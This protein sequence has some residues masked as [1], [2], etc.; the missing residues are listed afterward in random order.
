MAAY[1]SLLFQ[2]DT[3]CMADRNLEGTEA[4]SRFTFGRPPEFVDEIGYAG[5]RGS[6]AS[7]DAPFRSFRGIGAAAVLAIAVLAGVLLF[8]F[9]R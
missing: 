2:R 6:R 9:L 5:F 3:S 1:H 7:D 4:E 8:V